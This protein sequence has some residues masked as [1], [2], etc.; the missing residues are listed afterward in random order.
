M[1]LRGGVADR[2][3]EPS[4]QNDGRF[5]ARNTVKGLASHHRRVTRTSGRIGHET[6]HRVFGTVL[7]QKYGVFFLSGKRTEMQPNMFECLTPLRSPALDQTNQRDPD[8]S[9]IK[10]VNDLPICFSTHLLRS[11]INYRVRSEVAVRIVWE[12]FCDA[13]S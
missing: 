3:S 9:S 6:R 12:R 1:G 2:T 13:M 4:L 5:A 11:F 8:F 10:V 7:G